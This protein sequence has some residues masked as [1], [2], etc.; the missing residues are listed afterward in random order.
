MPSRISMASLRSLQMR[1]SS[2]T[3][4][5]SQCLAHRS[6]A[7]ANL[8]DR[9]SALRDIRTGR[10][11][12]T[13]TATRIEADGVGRSPYIAPTTAINK[14]ADVAPS[15]KELYG[16]LDQLKI[17]AANYVDSSRLALALRSLERNDAVIRIAILSMNGDV[18]QV[19][20][21]VRLLLADPLGNEEAWE[22]ELLSMEP[23]ESVLLR[24]GDE[25]DAV[26]SSSQ[27]RTL[28]IPSSTLQK[29]RLEILVS[30]LHSKISVSEATPDEI[31]IKS[32]LVP[33]LDSQATSSGQVS[34]L[35]YPIH[36]AL[37][38]GEGVKSLVDYGRFISGVN[39]QVLQPEMV[40]IAAEAPALSSVDSSQHKLGDPLLLDVQS[41]EHALASIRQSIRN[42]IAWEHGWF[43]AGIPP[44]SSWL[45][46]GTVSANDEL[47]PAVKKLVE[48]VL[49][50]AETS[51]LSAENAAQL[52]VHAATVP[53]SIRRDI[54]AATASWSEDAHN[55][56]RNQLDLAFSSK[57]WARLK[58]YKLFWRSDDVTMLLSEIMEQRWLPEAEKGA[59][60][61][62]GRIEGSGLMDSNVKMK[63]SNQPTS[64]PEAAPEPASS[65]ITQPIGRHKY[66]MQIARTREALV[67]K[68]IP[69]LQALSQKLVLETG[70]AT[71]ITTTLTAMAYI[72]FANAT[73]FEAG[74]IF[75]FGVVI[76]LKRL[77]NKWETARD[78]WQG[79]VREEGRI[80]LKK[81][82]DAI[83][84]IV[85]IGGVGAIDEKGAED[86]RKAKA[87]VNAAREAL[88][89]MK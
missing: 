19:K 83:K 56:L 55:E 73:L 1:I 22:Q 31:A 29:H 41:G 9:I 62:A 58:W 89:R 88:R 74:A 77:Q 2:R 13:A 82:E 65:D 76:S 27:I 87:A 54:L 80:A 60:Y 50:H 45:V 63:L 10:F 20:R 38:V 5:C 30:N 47:K 15:N 37:L 26:R 25:V 23:G 28:P 12:S 67:S 79:E 71:A 24:Y 36:K 46:A 7:R 85:E 78:F 61:L 18:H 81:T 39:L 17:D 72:G 43:K 75:A 11:A 68:T 51:I 33:A 49:E 70:S 34:R 32:I 86:R 40:Q 4:C 35:T 84:E 66:P 14:P 69:A 57:N 21:L 44:L 16:A 42:A 64:L 8:R 53:A 59:I 48:S 3:F 52:A 6:V